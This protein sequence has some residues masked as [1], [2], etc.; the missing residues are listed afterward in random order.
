MPIKVGN[1]GIGEIY[2]GGTKIAQAYR[3]STLIFSSAPAFDGYVVKCMRYDGSS[4][5]VSAQGFKINGTTVSSSIVKKGYLYTQ[6]GGLQTLTASDIET[7]CGEHDQ[8]IMWGKGCEFWFETNVALTAFMWHCFEY[9]QPEGTWNVTINRYTGDTIESTPIYSD[10]A[11][12]S[13]NAWLTF[14]I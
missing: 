13:A 1:T 9:F 10:T 5:Q 6:G 14:T 12:P 4:S 2:V 3:G 7:A 8:F 11:S